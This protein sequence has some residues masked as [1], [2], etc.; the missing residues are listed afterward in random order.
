MLLP[1]KF[2][3]LHITKYDAKQDLV[4]WLRCYALSIK[5]AGGNNDTKCVYFPFWT[6]L[7]LHGSSHSRSTWLTSGTSSRISSPATSRALWVARVL[8][9]TW[10][11]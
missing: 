4:Q 10:Q 1:E 7:H 11:W 6:K 9:W 3:P 2:K 8:A 5:N